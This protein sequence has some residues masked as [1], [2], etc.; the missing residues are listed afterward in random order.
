MKLNVEVESRSYV[1]Q[2]RDE[3]DPWDRDNT[4]QSVHGVRVFVDDPKIQSWSSWGYPD[5]DL[6]VEVGDIVYVVLL[7][8]STG[9]TFGND[10]GEYAVADAFT[11][12]ELANELEEWYRRWTSSDYLMSRNGK[13]VPF[14]GEF[15][16]KEYRIPWAG[17]FEHFENVEIYDCLVEEA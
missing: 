11:D 4:A 17:Y 16:G 10:D 6:D 15:K 2:P 3:S 9:D 1:T 5:I 13:S 14:T 8:Y 7:R 12:K